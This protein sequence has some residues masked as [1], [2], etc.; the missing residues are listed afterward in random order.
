MGRFEEGSFRQREQQVL[1]GRQKASE[2]G[3][4]ITQGFA[5]QVR[6]VISILSAMGSQ[7][8]I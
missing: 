5:G 6:S 2:L 4:C 7:R 8:R 1:L 3:Q